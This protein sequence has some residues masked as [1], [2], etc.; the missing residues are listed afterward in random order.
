MV[1]FAEQTKTFPVL[2]LV[3]QTFSALRVTLTNARWELQGRE[4]GQWWSLSLVDAAEVSGGQDAITPSHLPAAAAA[5]MC[6]L[7]DESGLRI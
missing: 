7:S 2:P 4:A 3:K 1:I 5:Y 6:T